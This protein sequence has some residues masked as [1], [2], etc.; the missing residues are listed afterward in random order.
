MH[1]GMGISNKKLQTTTNT[2][3]ND[4]SLSK[5][6]HSKWYFSSPK[7][8]HNTP[9]QPIEAASYCLHDCVSG[10]FLSALVQKLQDHLC[11]LVPCCYY[12]PWLTVCICF[13]IFHSSYF[14]MDHS[15]SIYIIIAFYSYPWL[16][17]CACFDWVII[18]Y[19]FQRSCCY[20]TTT[21]TTERFGLLGGISWAV[22]CLLNR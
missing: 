5:L 15:S 18:I 22:S 10:L 20:Y 13:T 19:H 6:L 17:F 7:T 1:V 16:H 14:I 8:L 12:W 2:L 9:I 11:F 4:R 21:T 3:S